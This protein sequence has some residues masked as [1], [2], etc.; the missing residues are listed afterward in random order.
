MALDIC[1]A[2]GPCK[3]ASECEVSEYWDA[4]KHVLASRPNVQVPLI[5]LADTNGRVPTSVPPHTGDLVHGIP[6][7]A[8]RCFL[9]LV[10]QQQLFIPSTCA[11]C[12]TGSR[13]DTWLSTAGKGH[14]IDFIALPV[15]ADRSGMSAWT[16]PQLDVVCTARDHVPLLVRAPLVCAPDEHLVARRMAR[17]SRSAMTDPCAL[18]RFHDRMASQRQ[19]CWAAHAHDHHFQVFRSIQEAVIEEFPVGPSLPAKRWITPPTWDALLRRRELRR[20][21]RLASLDVARCL[22]AEAFGAWLCARSRHVPVPCDVWSSR[23]ALSLLR[24]VHAASIRNLRMSE[25]D[26]HSSVEADRSA[27]H[28]QMAKEANTAVATGNSRELFRIIKSLIP[29]QARPPQVLK[30]ADGTS[31]ITPVQVRQSWQ[32]HF[33]EK[34]DGV[35]AHMSD[36]LVVNTELQNSQFLAMSGTELDV[37]HI[38]SLYDVQ[39]LY[40]K[41]VSNR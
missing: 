31:A 4:L 13:Q 34:L 2:H 8:G 1:V 7:H 15:Q 41:L 39:A 24:C 35:V 33:A 29:R 3:P 23:D 12:W 17:S 21:A 19:P 9:E 6:D 10:K 38:P 27:H 16:D 37:K 36:L 22:L 18:A 14:R 25:H 26:I 11:L 40:S 5:M 28:A 32:S 20:H 30:K